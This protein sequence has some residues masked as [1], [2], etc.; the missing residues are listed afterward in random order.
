MDMKSTCL[1]TT[2]WAG[3]EC[4]EIAD[5]LSGKR[6]DVTA[7]GMPAVDFLLFSAMVPCSWCWS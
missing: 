6:G 1:T 3:M 4:W 7:G 5:R 2:M